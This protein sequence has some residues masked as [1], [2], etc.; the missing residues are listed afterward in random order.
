MSLSSSPQPIQRERRTSP[1][2]LVAVVADAT[3]FVAERP[4]F[5][6]YAVLHGGVFE[7]GLGAHRP[8][9]WFSTGENDS[10]RPPEVVRSHAQKA[11]VA[12][13]TPVDVHVYPGGHAVSPEEVDAVLAFWRR[14]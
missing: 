8:R 10:L 9:G 6:A 1:L 12:L 11:S 13:S 5:V 4:R 14:P 7:R 3:V 2:L